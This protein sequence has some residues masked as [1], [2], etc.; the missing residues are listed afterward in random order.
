MRPAPFDVRAVTGISEEEAARRLRDEGPNELPADEARSLW[1][2]SLDVV[3]QPM[4]LLLLGAGALY[5]LLGDAVEALTL[6][7]FVVVMIGVALYQ[8]RKTDNALGALKSLT[9]PRALVIRGGRERRVPGR[10]V[11]RGDVVILVEGD[12]VPADAEI[13][14]AHNLSVDES[15]LTGESGPVRKRAGDG[16]A[17]GGPAPP[18]GGDDAPFVYSGTLVVRGRGVAEVRST[19]ARTEI[20][21][22]GKS[23]GSSSPSPRTSSARSRASSASSPRPASA[24]A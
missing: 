16:D 23:L 7:S 17:R 14:D 8:E 24:C 11:A 20:G 2:T 5:L 6:L 15:L 3:K 4:L 21:K 13:L 1:R 12:R 10:E 18:P 19:G 22:I 9:S